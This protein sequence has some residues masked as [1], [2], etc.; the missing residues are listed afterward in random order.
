MHVQ[1]GFRWGRICA[2]QHALAYLFTPLIRFSV[3]CMPAFTSVATPGKIL[4]P[5]CWHLV[6]RV[7]DNFGDVGVLWRLA[8]QLRDEYGVQL[9]FFIDDPDALAK[10]APETRSPLALTSTEHASHHD[11]SPRSSCPTPGA[12]PQTLPRRLGGR[13]VAG[14]LSSAS[15]LPPS[16]A[17]NLLP[18]F[19][20]F[21][22]NVPLPP[23]PIEVFPLREDAPI[24][25]KA[26]V[27]V[28]GFQ[29]RLPLA[30]RQAWLQTP[31]TDRPRLIQLD[32]LSAEDW[33]ADMHGLTSLAPD[34]LRE[35]FFYPGF[36]PN[37][38]GLLLERGLL[39]ERDRFLANPA[40]RQRWLGEHGVQT[41]D[42]EL[43]VSLLCYPQAPL[44]SLLASWLAQID[45]S[46]RPC[47]H[48]LA[49]GADTQP[50]LDGLDAWIQRALEAAQR[51]SS[52]H[53]S[54]PSRGSAEQHSSNEGLDEYTPYLAASTP[55]P[56]LRLTRL[57]FLPQTEFDRLLWSCDLNLV[58]G[59]DSWIR[60]LWAGK[61]WLWQAYPQAEAAHLEK[62]DAFLT[63][64]AKTIGQAPLPRWQQAMRAWNS[65][66]DAP[67]RDII[68]WLY[69]LPAAGQ[70]AMTLSRQT[71]ADSA[72]L[73]QRLI[74]FAQR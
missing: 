33:V 32:Y 49:P 53:A 20:G 34:G 30:A 40:N 24:G 71:A 12:P 42:N 46:S 43:L 2:Y 70:L 14:G 29:V 68:R 15:T 8:R 5:P 18:N 11:P 39:A 50:H 9:R 41:H 66:N 26:D 31:T 60:A 27:V 61:P 38:G 62:L 10:L 35:S 52:R 7:I 36:G 13:E 63:R 48:L 6:C 19:Q 47:L 72:D 28:L 65:A 44:E 45:T 17:R 37:T 67:I 23:L 4:R 16:I 74:H 51:H 57:P 69:D 25:H 73:A 56:R 64:A 21:P 54:A 58:R 1:R 59:E 55:P 3:H 22:P